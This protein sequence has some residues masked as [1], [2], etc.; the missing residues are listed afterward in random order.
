MK[1]APKPSV[2]SSVRPPTDVSGPFV[3]SWS[4]VGD[5]AVVRV[6]GVVDVG[7]SATFAGELRHVITTKLPRLV[8]DLRRVTT[9]EA[10]GL[11]VL[12]DAHELAVEHGGWLRAAGAGQWLAD[13]I[14]A[15]GA[16]RPLDHYPRLADALPSYR[17]GIIGPPVK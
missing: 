5:C 7:T 16:V 15:A 3:C 2:V 1:P 14:R 11:R 17:P 13:L 6:A 9:M 10:T 8:V 4:A 12:T